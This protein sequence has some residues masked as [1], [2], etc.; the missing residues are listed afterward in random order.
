MNKEINVIK[1]LLLVLL[2]VI[3]VLKLQSQGTPKV[4]K[5]STTQPIEIVQIECTAD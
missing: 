4:S 5:T 2:F 1:G 3:L